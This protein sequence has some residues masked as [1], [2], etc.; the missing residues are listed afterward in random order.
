L[1]VSE[2]LNFTQAA[3]DCGITQ[4]ALTRSIQKLEAQLEHQLFRR[5]G[6]HTHLTDI[7]RILQPHFE[8]ILERVATAT[9]VARAY[10]ESL[11]SIRLGVLATLGPAPLAPLLAEFEADSPTCSINIA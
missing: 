4:S 9:T 1:A 7:A 2:R 3:R 5:E 8:A 10:Q 11:R 6:R